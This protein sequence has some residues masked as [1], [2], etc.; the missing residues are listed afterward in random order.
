MANILNLINDNKW[1]EAITEIKDLFDPLTDGKNLFHFACM[2]GHIEII[3]H[4][5]S[6]KSNMLILSDNEGNTGAHFL[7]LNGWDEILL[8]LVN[9]EPLF[10]KLK[11]NNDEFV[12]NLVIFR[13]DTLKKILNIMEKCDLIKYLNFIKYNGT[14]FILDI[15]DMINDQKSIYFDIFDMLYKFKIDWTI[16]KN[17]PPLI[18]LL[19]KKKIGIYEHILNNYNDINHDIKNDFQYSPLLISIIQNLNKIAI[20]IIDKK[21]DI[22][23]SGLENKYVPLSLCFKKGLFDVAEKLI[24]TEK[25]NYNKNDNMLNI[26]IHYLLEYVNKYR[27]LLVDSKIKDILKTVIYNS[28]LLNINSNNVSPLHLLIKYDIWKDYI[29]IIQNKQLDLS[30]LDK[31]KNNPLVYLKD[32]DVALFTKILDNQIK[33]GKKWNLNKIS[34]IIF[35]EIIKDN[36]NGIFNADGIHNIIYLMYIL[37]NYHNCTIPVQCHIPEKFMWEK[38]KLYN[39][40]ISHDQIVDL[41]SSIVLFYFETFYSIIPHIIFWRD[42]N[43]NFKVKDI[44]FLL[45]RSILSEKYRFIIM[46]L[47]LIPHSDTLHANIIIYDKIRNTLIRFEPYGDW[48]LL[49]SYFLD[50]MIIKI[51]KN[52][53]DKSKHKSLKYLRPSDYLDKTKFQSVSLG[54]EHKHKNLGDPSGYCLAWCYWFLELKLLNPDINER[55]LVENALNEIILSSDNDNNNPLLNHIRGYAKHLDIEKNKIFEQLGINKHDFYKL[56]YD[57]EKINLYTNY[58]NTYTLKLLKN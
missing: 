53:I 46:K 4:F 1:A 50:K 14:T 12:Y 30:I 55:E 54:D 43:I 34:T 8:K 58:I 18:Y 13:H 51:F 36:E 57:T 26:P 11:N 23:Y 20:K 7:A 15:I 38:Y 21:V 28:N 9:I 45:K 6:L 25:L 3:D 39:Q 22:N 10:L 31:E 24:N 2:R 49:D 52:A 42:K 41:M 17:K 33:V 56:S 16:P 32:N 48:E 44:S 37:N 27:E 5:I 40:S 29:D 19:T 35:P 47:S